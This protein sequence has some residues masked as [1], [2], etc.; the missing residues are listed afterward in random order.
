MGCVGCAAILQTVSDTDCLRR[1]NAIQSVEL[2]YR[3]RNGFKGRRR[4]GWKR[5]EQISLDQA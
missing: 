1:R 5:E 4:S 2:K 3:V